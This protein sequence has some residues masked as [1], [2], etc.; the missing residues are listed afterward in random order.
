MNTISK[1]YLPPDDIH[2][3]FKPVIC[4]PKAEK[5]RSSRLLKTASAFLKTLKNP[6]LSFEQWQRLE[7]HRSCRYAE[8][9]RARYFQPFGRSV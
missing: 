2:P 1:S 8:V 7:S 6:D 3:S 5:K 9:P 4:T